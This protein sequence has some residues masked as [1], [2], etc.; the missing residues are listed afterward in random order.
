MSIALFIAGFMSIPLLLA[1]CR[2]FGIYTC[3]QECEAQ[4]FTLFGKV[5]GTLER[6]GLHLPISSFGPRA[7]LIPFFGKR[8]VV[9]TALRQHYLRGQMVNSEEG[10]PM[11]VGI[12]YEMQ[13][14]EPIAYLFTNANPDGSL[15]ANVTSSTIST[16]SNLEMEKMLEDRHSLS[17]TVRKAVSPLSEKWG[18]RLGSVYIRKVEFTDQ[19]MVDNITEKVVKRLV[20]VTSAMKQD[21]ENRVGLIKSETAF[22]VSQKMAEAA[23]ARPQIVGRKLNEI[24]KQDPEV[25]STVLEVMEINSLLESG[26]SIDVLPDSGNMLYQIG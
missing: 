14:Q 1:V 2:A 10:T 25:L 7:M 15:Q 13:V 5:I 21:G 16:L 23:A 18:Y 19:Q 9:N 6:P 20:Q 3:V 4:V 12:W 11:G 26:A 22:K 17:R 8:Y 24:G